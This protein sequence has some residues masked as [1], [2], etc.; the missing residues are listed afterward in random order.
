MIRPDS[1][2]RHTRKIKGLSQEELEARTGVVQVSISK[3]E[4]RGP[5]KAIVNAIR[6]ARALG[7]TVEDL[8]GAYV[9]SPANAAC[10]P[11]EAA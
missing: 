11:G 9:D 4:R 8:F 6:L 10:D 3:L 7:V 5:T 2:M 1:P